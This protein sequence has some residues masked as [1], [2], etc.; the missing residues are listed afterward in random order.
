MPFNGHWF[1]LNFIHYR[2][3]SLL[4]ANI[5]YYCLSLFSVDNIFTLLWW[6]YDS[7]T[8]DLFLLTLDTAYRIGQLLY[9]LDLLFEKLAIMFF[10]L[11]KSVSK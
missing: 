8:D 4:L 3:S 5:W 6:T 1:G 2:L 9:R 7:F 10:L 11:L